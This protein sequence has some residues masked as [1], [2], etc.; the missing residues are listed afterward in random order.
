ME[1]L[2]NEELLNVLGNFSVI[3]LI[4][5]TREL[6]KRWNLK[7]EP[8][9]QKAVTTVQEAVVTKTEFDVMLVSVP[10]DKKMSVIKAVREIMMLGLK[11]SKDFVESAPKL[12]KESA[13]AEEAETIKNKLIEAGALVEVK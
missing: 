7:A 10:A 13:T 5:L 6:E 2:S 4:Q 12:L 9:V 11:E 3:Q 1:N 8:Q